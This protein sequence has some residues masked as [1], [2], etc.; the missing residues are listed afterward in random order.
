MTTQEALYHIK[1]LLR[2]NRTSLRYHEMAAI[3]HLVIVSEL[4]TACASYGAQGNKMQVLIS[5][6]KEGWKA[7]WG[8]CV[9]F[10]STREEAQRA[11]ETQLATTLLAEAQNL[12]EVM[13]S[14]GIVYEART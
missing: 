7:E 9:G 12:L 2:E 6:D 8:T 10:G 13:V 4:N 3:E 1:A 5:P 11:F 14:Q